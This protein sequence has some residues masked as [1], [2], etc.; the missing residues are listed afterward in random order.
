V[1]HQPA[2]RHKRFDEKVLKSLEALARGSP[3]EVLLESALA[4]R[5]APIA[6]IVRRARLDAE[7]A[8]AALVELLGSGMLVL[9]EEGTPSIASDLL[10]IA[11]PHWA[12]LRERALQTVADYHQGFP[13]RRGLSRE[14][15]KS[16]L[17]LSPRVYNSVLRTLSTERLLVQQ[18]ALVALPSH[19]ISFSPEQ[20]SRIDG[21]LRKF[22][23]NPHATPSVKESQTEIGE[24]VLNALIE[25][26]EL[27]PV[28]QD[29]IFRKS[30]YDAMTGRIKTFLQQNGQITLAEVRDLFDTSRKYAQALLEHLDAAGVTVRSGDFRKLRQ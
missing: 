30:D 21:L 13:L 7:P 29:V 15:L 27:V 24:D 6:E 22:A 25:L 2:G 4:S 3:A 17:G 18:E 1:D 12:A 28:S 10:A 9:L 11:R 8:A 16:R 19:T 23:A 5:A 14:E 26:D 20:R